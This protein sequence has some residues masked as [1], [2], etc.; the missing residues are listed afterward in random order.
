MVPHYMGMLLA[1]YCTSL[2]ILQVK[3]TVVL[4]VTASLKKRPNRVVY[5]LAE[6]FHP[7]LI[8]GSK[9]RSLLQRGEPKRCSTWVGSNFTC[10]N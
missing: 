4:L 5:D 2:K 1:L 6:P 7:F 3:N 9:A 10:K 8:F